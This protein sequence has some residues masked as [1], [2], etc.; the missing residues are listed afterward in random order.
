MPKNTDP[1]QLKPRYILLQLLGLEEKG[2]ITWTYRGKN[3][4]ITREKSDYQQPSWQQHFMAGENEAIYLV[5]SKK[6]IWA[7]D[8][9]SSKTNFQEL[10]HR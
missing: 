8:F 2:K 6:E 10:S 1:E 9:I 4:W 3:K 7:K 5:F